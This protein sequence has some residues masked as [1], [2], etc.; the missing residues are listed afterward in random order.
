MVR[1]IFIVMGHRVDEAMLKEIIA[2]VD[3]DG[4]LN[5]FRSRLYGFIND[6]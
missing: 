4:T 1:T 3:I 6:D 5:L 2:E